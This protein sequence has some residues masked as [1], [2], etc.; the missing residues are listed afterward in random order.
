MRLDRAFRQEP[1]SHAEK[2]QG[3]REGRSQ[4]RTVGAGKGGE[5][6][7]RDAFLRVGASRLVILKTFIPPALYFIDPPDRTVVQASRTH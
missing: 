3:D 6:R 7:W 5:G 4:K 1:Q 2:Y